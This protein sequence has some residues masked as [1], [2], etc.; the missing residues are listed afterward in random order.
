MKEVT[1]TQSMTDEDYKVQIAQ[2]FEKLE[3]DHKG[4]QASQERIEALRAQTQA[5]AER[6]RK[7]LDEIKAARR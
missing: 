3:R 6:T 2:M 5:S 7:I 4:M 1:S